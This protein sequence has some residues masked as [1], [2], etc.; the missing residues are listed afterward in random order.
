MAE[1]H[2]AYVSLHNILKRINYNTENQY[3]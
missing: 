3:L 1:L 2:S